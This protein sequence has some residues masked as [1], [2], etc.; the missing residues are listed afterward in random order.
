MA[1]GT[2]AVARRLASDTDARQH[3]PVRTGTFLA[4]S[5]VLASWS[6]ARADEG[7][8]PFWTSGQYGSFAAVPPTPGW[9][10]QTMAYYYDGSASQSSRRGDTVSN[11]LDSQGPLLFIQPTYAPHT[12][13][14]AGQPSVALSFGYG[15]NRTRAEESVSAGGVELDRSDSLWG[16]TDLAP[17]ASLAWSRGVDNWMVYLTGN[18]P[19]GS[20]DSERIANLGIGHGAID[21]GGAYTWFDAQNGREFSAVL[22]FTQNFENDSTSY[23]NGIDSHLDWSLSQSLP[24]G[25]QL[26][27]V[28]YAYYQLSGDSGAGATL[29]GFESRVVALGPKLGR[30]FRVG[31]RQWTANLRGY[32]EFWA[33]N[34]LE[35]FAV[36]AT[37]T[38]PI[39]VGG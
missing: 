32:H 34:R 19:V 18:I 6:E 21:G 28:G 27:L 16:G 37:L 12:K 29:G 10:L 5:L 14:L 9:S 2:A 4:C 22:G 24:S 13:L 35:G 33:R 23:K 26:G 8:T 25:W 39:P 38:V 1:E 31:A 7:G 15:W 36:F 20:Y 17:F 30:T 3:R 11:D